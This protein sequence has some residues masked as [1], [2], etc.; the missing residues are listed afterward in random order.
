MKT[1]F[2]LFLSLLLLFSVSTSAQALVIFNDWSLN[3]DAVGEPG[4]TG[5]IDNINQILFDGIAY[6]QT[7]DTN[8]NSTPDIGEIG[9]TDGYL[10]SY[11]YTETPGQPAPTI[12]SWGF[13]MT[14]DFSTNSVGID[15]ATGSSFEHLAAGTTIS[16]ASLQRDGILDIYVDNTPDADINTGTGFTNGTLI[17]KLAYM[18]GLGG[19]FSP[20]TLDGHDDGTYQLIWAL[21]NVLLDS[22]GNDLQDGIGTSTYTIAITDTNFDG[23]DDENNTF[24]STYGSSVWTP[25]TQSAVNFVASLNGSSSLGVAPIPEATT[26]LLFGFGLLGIA[27]INRK[28]KV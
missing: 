9:A 28:Q 23:D 18:Q 24:D 15:P 16:N 22:N 14:F 17:A 20:G 4:V 12:E 2:A 3:L 10:A 13:E 21:D 7:D 25:G 6:S 5:Q 26:M 11:L 19:L 27:G 8:G 1:L